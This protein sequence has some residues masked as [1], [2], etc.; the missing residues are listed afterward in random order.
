MNGSKFEPHLFFQR[1][2]NVAL[3]VPASDLF[4]FLKRSLDL[5]VQWAAMVRRITGDLSVVRAGGTVDATD[6]ENVLFVRV[7]PVDVTLEEEGIVTRNRFQCRAEVRV[8]IRVIPER[9]ELTSFQGTVL[10]SHRVVQAAGIARYLQPALRAAL[11]QFA[12]EH[13]AAKL[14]DASLTDSLSAAVAKALEGPCFTAGLAPDGEPSVRFESATLRKVQDAQQDAARHHAEH[15]AARQVQEA[16]ERAQGQHLDHLTSLLSRLNEMASASPDVELP[17]LIR[18][19]KERERGELYEAL[20]AA[21]PVRTQTRWIVA[22]A[23]DELIYFDPRNLN[24]PIRRLRVVGTAGPIRSIKTAKD[25][26]GGMVLLLGAATGVYR[27]P[28]DWTE[29]DSTLLVENPPTV[30]GGFNSV[31][32]VG[33]RVLASHSELGLCEWDVDK[34]TAARPWFESMT[35][36]AKAVRGVQFFEGDLYCAID[37]RVVRWPADEA[38]EQPPHIYTGSMTTISALC[39]TA[40]GLFVGNG[41]G[42]ILHWPKG[43][44]SKPE[45]L[46]TGLHRAAESVWLLATQGVR[47]VVYTDTSLHVHARVLG[48][49]FTCRYEAGGQTIRRVEVAPDVLVATNDLRDRLI[50]WSPGQ[51]DSPTATIGVSRLCG[52]SI[53]DVCL[54][55]QV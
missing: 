46:H 49:N 43:R 50:C 37:D 25:A 51:P 52:H 32:M 53:Q 29:P 5:P 27:W 28:I 9:S 10:G 17:D 18:S 36:D 54:V 45:R 1:A 11:A 24:E 41:D 44:D 30:R 22:A 6:V 4:G 35:R 26:D 21:E 39:P 34:P 15:Q 7:T 23:G 8:R 2:D 47:R 16:L 20:F 33:D 14:V 40:D 48:D 42:D 3:H 38:A 19:F 31:A 55:P 13:D 12:A